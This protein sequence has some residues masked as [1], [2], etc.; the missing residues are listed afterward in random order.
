MLYNTNKLLYQIRG[1]TVDKWGKDQTG[2]IKYKINNYGFRSSKEYDWVPDYAFFGSSSVFGIGVDEDKCLVS[3]FDNAQNYGIAGNYLNNDSVVNLTNFVN[4]PIYNNTKIIFFWTERAQHEDI[5]C[6]IDQVNQVVDHVIHIS[7]GKKY[8]GAIN[9]MPQI[10]F[11]VSN[12][13]PGPK[14]HKLWAKTIK[15][16]LNE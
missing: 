16:L 12:T 15:L 10:D 5:A 2:A 13:H 6:L 14:T 8:P 1:Q 9:L 3:Y 4:S 11:D 7:Q